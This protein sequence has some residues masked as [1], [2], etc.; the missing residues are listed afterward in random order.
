MSETRPVQLQVNN[1][2]AWKNV[3]HFDAGDQVAGFKVM[4]AAV[5]L[6]QVAP[7]T[8]FRIAMSG[9]LSEALMHLDKGEWKKVR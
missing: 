9:G 3:C 7:S 5:L 1:T 6:Q 2:G 8:K 4:E